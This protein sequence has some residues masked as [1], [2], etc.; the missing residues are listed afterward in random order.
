MNEE[1][2]DCPHDDVPKVIQYSIDIGLGKIGHIRLCQAC[3]IISNFK[4]VIKT[5]VIDN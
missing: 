2:Y 4:H 5:E 1:S 3:R